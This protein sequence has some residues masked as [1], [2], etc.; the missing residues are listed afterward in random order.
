MPE[1]LPASFREN[2]LFRRKI[3]FAQRDFPG[4]LES[5]KNKKKFVM[6]TGLMPSGKFHLG[7]MLLVQQMIFYQNLGAKLY[8]TVA[9]L[10]AYNTRGKNLEELRKI[11]IEQYLTNYIALGLKPKNLDFY[12]GVALFS[13]YLIL[14]VYNNTL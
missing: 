11:A 12:F 1:N 14:I 3:I 8:V 13:L 5:I 6:M 7:H 2:L 10:E 4:I 9:D